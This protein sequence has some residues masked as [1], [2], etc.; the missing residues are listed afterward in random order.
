MN[1]PSR[2]ELL[3][4]VVF[5]VL[6]DVVVA[7]GVL[8]ASVTKP[9][10]PG[11]CRLAADLAEQ[12]ALRRVDEQAVVVRVGDEQ[13]AV[14]VDAE[15]RGPALF[16]DRRLP[17]A[18]VIA[19][20]VEDLDAGGHIDDVE[21]VLGVDGDRAG[22]LKAAVGKAAAAPGADE[23]AVGSRSAGAAA[24]GEEEQEE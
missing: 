10:L 22:F 5:A 24:G 18:E 19:V 16:V 2:R 17:V 13:V 3:D 9:N 14:A 7:V 11:P 23:V 21:L 15:A 12:L 20:G 8:D 1:F 6:G 4:A